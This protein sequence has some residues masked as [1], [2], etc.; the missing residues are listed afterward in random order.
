[1]GS[2]G[3]I[4]FIGAIVALAV[5]VWGA[6]RSRQ[7]IT[8]AVVAVVVAVVAAG[9]GWYAFAESESLPWT[10]GYGVVALLS[11]GVG[12]KHVIGSRDKSDG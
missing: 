1:M 5:V 8:I 12:M 4:I 10:I 6:F 11:V 3:A 7:S 9:C 2:Q